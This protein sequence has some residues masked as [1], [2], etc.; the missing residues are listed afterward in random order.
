[1]GLGKG[2][3][4]SQGFARAKAEYW[5][6]LDEV[7]D[8]SWTGLVASE[9][10]SDQPQEEYPWLG[11]NPAVRKWE[12]ERSAQELRGDK[13]ILVNDDYEST[14]RVKLRDL[15]RDKT[16]QTAAR[17]SEM[18]GRVGQLPLKLLSALILANGTAY[19]GAA[20]YSNSH[21][22]GRSGTIDNLM[23]NADGGLAGGATPTTAQMAANILAMIARLLSFKDDQGE[24]MNEGASSFLVM[25]PV[26]LLGATLGAINDQFLSGG[27]ANTLKSSGFSVK[28]AANARLSTAAD[29]T[30]DDC[31]LFR[32]DAGIGA[33]IYQEELRALDELGPD[34]EHAFKFNEV[35]FGAHISGTAGYGRFEYSVKGTLS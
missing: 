14:V 10:D 31:Y 9:F 33:M 20:F 27:A 2:T 22:V 5:A 11:Q 13:V 16:G 30:P 18:G 26:N 15:R 24:P 1:M 3:A 25:V 28:A 29:A 32:T 7:R 17:M 35:L 34:S 12:G 6:K 23:T 4:Y 19:D 21:S 8:S